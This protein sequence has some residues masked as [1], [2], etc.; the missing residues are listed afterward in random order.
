MQTAFDYHFLLLHIPPH[1]Q[2]PPQDRVSFNSAINACSKAAQWQRALGL[3]SQ[4]KGRPLGGCGDVVM[5][6]DL[7]AP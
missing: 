2:W 6:W 1:L 4:L 7:V 3:L 5:C